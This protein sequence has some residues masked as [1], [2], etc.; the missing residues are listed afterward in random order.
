M[1]I[2]KQTDEIEKLTKKVAKTKSVRKA[3]IKRESKFSAI[4]NG[5]KESAE[6][7]RIS[8]KKQTKALLKESGKKSAD[9][10]PGAKAKT[11]KK[12]SPPKSADS[13]KRRKK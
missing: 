4:V 11:T 12:T 13:V 8:E 1:I 10:Q 3:A 9:K 7:S 6:E 5:K 2:D